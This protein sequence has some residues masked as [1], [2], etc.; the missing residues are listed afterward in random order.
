VVIAAQVGVAQA[1]I[2]TLAGTFIVVRVLHGLF[3][4]TDRASL[5]S[6][7]YIAGL[8]CVVGLFVAGTV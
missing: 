3:Y 1:T 4:I 7:A 6:L 2:D 5:R 8:L